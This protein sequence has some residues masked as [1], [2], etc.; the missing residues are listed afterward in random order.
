MQNL[1]KKPVWP[2]QNI[3]DL[4][5]AWVAYQKSRSENISFYIAFFCIFS[6]EEDISGLFFIIKQ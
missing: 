4:S 1:R 6:N 2:K 3:S 5:V